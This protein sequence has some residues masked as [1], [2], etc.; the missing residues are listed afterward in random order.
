M[1]SEDTQI[2][3]HALGLDHGAKPYRNH[4]VAAKGTLEWAVCEGLEARGLLRRG[5]ATSYGQYFYVTEA[6]A[7]AVGWP[8]PC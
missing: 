4:Y 2:I 7:R 1:T 5:H 6:G 8:L 3:K